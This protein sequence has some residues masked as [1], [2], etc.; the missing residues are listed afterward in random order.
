MRENSFLTRKKFLKLVG[1]SSLGSIVATL[2]NSC[3]KNQSS[4]PKRP[5]KLIDVPPTPFS[6][7]SS[8]PSKSAPPIKKK[9]YTL[10]T[11]TFNTITVDS[12]G[13]TI[14]QQTKQAKYFR[15]NLRKGITIDMVSIPNGKFLMGAYP[16]DEGKNND[17]IPQHQ[18]T[19]PSFFMGKYLV[20]QA[21]WQAVMKNNP[22]Y[23]KRANRPVENVSWDDCVEFCQKLSSI[24]GRECRLPSEAE[25]EYACRAGTTTPFYFGEMITTELVNFN[26]KYAYSGA[27]VRSRQQT[28]P[29]GSFPPNSFGL[30]DMHGNLCEW[31]A[32][33][34]HETYDDAPTDGS[35]WEVGSS[36]DKVIRGGTWKSD[37]PWSCRSARRANTFP[38]EKDNLSGFRVVCS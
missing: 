9:N 27:K 38:W 24:I 11:F 36:P 23:F 28:T 16:T 25:W 32:D 15:A 20:T 31:C 26:D 14:K 18:V 8:S 10:H 4:Q 13:K 37:H 1:L 7:P 30:Y 35:A 29:V 34:W 2:V 19:V 3:A 21:Q 12:K 33:T 22:S 6:T 17:E 5:P